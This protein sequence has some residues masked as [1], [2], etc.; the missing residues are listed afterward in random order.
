M[1]E[2]KDL[3]ITLGKF[4]LKDIN[5]SISDREYFVVLGPTGAGKTI[6]LECI[7][8][9]RRTKHGEIWLGGNNVNKLPPEQ[10]NIGYVPQDYVL[11]PFLNVLNNITFGLKQ[12]TDNKNKI[13]EK[14]HEIADLIGISHLLERDTVSLSGGEKQ[15]VALARALASSPKILL[16]D[17]PLSALDLQTARYLRFELK[18]IHRDLGITTVHITHNQMEAEEMADRVAILNKGEINQVGTAEEIFF[19]PTN[20]AVMNYLGRP[21]ILDCEDC[22][23][24]GQGIMEADCRGL[25]I[26]VPHDGKPFKRIII[27][28][29]DVYVDKLNPGCNKVNCFKG[30]ITDIKTSANTVRLRFKVGENM[31]RSELPYHVFDEM[32]LS[33]GMEAFVQLSLRRIKIFERSNRNEPSAGNNQS[34]KDRI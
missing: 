1:I 2:I 4:F 13:K 33:E 21:N 5:L 15:R 27:Y 23:I 14:A 20:A 7:A 17:E 16:L 30:I 10:R 22:R 31:I 9:L 12:T 29:R 11:F 19:H 24:I 25:K 6:L 34:S 3:S 28:P 18:K 32:G 26:I 8:G